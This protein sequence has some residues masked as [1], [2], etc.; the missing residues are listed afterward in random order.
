MLFETFPFQCR[1]N[2]WYI[3][4]YWRKERC[5]EGEMKGMGDERE[6]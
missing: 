2:I 1:K 6:M 5:E 3:A 4:G